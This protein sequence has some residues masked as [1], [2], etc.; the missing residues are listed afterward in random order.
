M[1]NKNNF[2]YTI[3][4]RELIYCDRHHLDDFGVD[5]S[6]SL[7]YMIHER[8]YDRFSQFTNYEEFVCELFNLAYYICTMALAEMHP[9]RR[10]GTFSYV[11]AHAMRGNFDYMAVVYSIV[12]LQIRQHK[13]D[14][15]SLGMNRLA[16]EFEKE[17]KR[18]DEDV[19]KNV[20][21]SVVDG[22]E[23]YIMRGYGSLKIPP[24]SDFRLREITPEVL[25]DTCKVFKWDEYFNDDKNRV[26]YFIDAIGVTDKEKSTIRDFIRETLHLNVGDVDENVPEI[27]PQKSELEDT[28]ARVD[29]LVKENQHQKSLIKELENKYE[30]LEEVKE[31]LEMVRKREKGIS[32]GI[33]Q[34]QAALLGL[35]LANVMGF[36]YTNKK[37]LAPL[38]HNL[39]GWGEAKL[40]KCLSSAPCEREDRDKL[41]NMFKDLCPLLHKTIMNWGVVPSEETPLETP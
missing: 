2:D 8:I 41:A 38:L 28:M 13:W 29:T 31:Q 26:Q 32:L 1:N 24:A 40:A 30:N 4:P 23:R 20:Y 34:G 21:R 22:I 15:Q 37:H 10:F 39:F 36:N 6:S 14:F 16:E 25:S 19:Y 18:S 3:V 35:S 33:N 9:E 12:L 17:L 11:T 27:Q 5:E 7:N